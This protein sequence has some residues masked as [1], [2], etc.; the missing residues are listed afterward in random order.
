MTFTPF[1]I[2]CFL[3]QP[4]VGG[5]LPYAEQLCLVPKVSVTGLTLFIITSSL[6]LQLVVF[7]FIIKTPGA[8][9]AL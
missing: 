2:W 9:L 6:V 8:D 3:P 4:L 5:H 7:N 1:S